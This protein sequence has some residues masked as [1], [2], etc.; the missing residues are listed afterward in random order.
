MNS[1]YIFY[2]KSL[3]G[4]LTKHPDATLSFEYDSSWVALEG[5]FPLSPVLDL[6]HSGLFNNRKSLAFFEN[7][8]PE[9]DVKDRLEKLIVKS[10]DT[11]YQFLEQYGVDCAGAFVL[12][13]NKKIPRIRL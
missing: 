7:L 6:K 9:G 10:L 3:V 12:T 8:V 13:S 2:K 1:L 4:L 11:G 5:S